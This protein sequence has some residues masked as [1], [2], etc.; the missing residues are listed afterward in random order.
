[1]TPDGPFIPLVISSAGA[2]DVAQVHSPTPNSTAGSYSIGTTTYPS[3]AL[4][5]TLSLHPTVFVQK[6]AT[7]SSVQ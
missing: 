1:M 3:R 5:D 4:L 7:L 2:G 6:K